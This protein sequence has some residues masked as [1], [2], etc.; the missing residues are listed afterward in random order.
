[1]GTRHLIMVLKDN[2]YK[3]AQYGQ[4]DGH[5]TGQGVETKHF[6]KDRLLAKRGIQTFTKQLDRIQI[7]AD[8]EVMARWEAQ[9][10]KGGFAGLDVEDSFD[11]LYPQLSRSCGSDILEYVYSAEAPEIA[12]SIDFAKDSLFCEFAYLVNMDTEELEIFTGFNQKPLSE[13]D[14]FY[15]LQSP[16]MEYYPIKLYKSFKFNEIPDMQELEAAYYHDEET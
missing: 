3:V 7:I 2:Q 12:H 1:M 15:F 4:W 8:A 9:G 13:S 14:R 11:N 16:D 10:A 6:I 5:F